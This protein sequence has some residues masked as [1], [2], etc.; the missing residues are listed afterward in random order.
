M[1]KKDYSNKNIDK[2]I[3]SL[4]EYIYLRYRYTLLGGRDR[5]IQK[6]ILSYKEGNW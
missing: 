2:V 5:V 6:K 3:L 1:I 4:I